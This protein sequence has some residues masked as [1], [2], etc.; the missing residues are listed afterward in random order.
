[1]IKTIFLSVR[2]DGALLIMLWEFHK[3]DDISA[4]RVM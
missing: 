2:E 4:A 1:M 3:M